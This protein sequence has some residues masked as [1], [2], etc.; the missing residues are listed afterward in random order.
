MKEAREARAKKNGVVVFFPKEDGHGI[1][2]GNSKG[3]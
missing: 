2:W 3:L 1:N